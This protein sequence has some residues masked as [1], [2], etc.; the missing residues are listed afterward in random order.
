M[1]GNLWEILKQTVRQGIQD[2]RKDIR[3]HEIKKHPERRYWSE[4]EWQFQHDFKEL[5]AGVFAAPIMTLLSSFAY[6][7]S[8]SNDLFIGNLFGLGAIMT[9]SSMLYYYHR[10]R[11][12]ERI[13]IYTLF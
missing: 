3:E 5:T 6:Q 7:S 8:N 11:K 4:Q 2:A 10:M 13:K 1:S 12:S 9:T